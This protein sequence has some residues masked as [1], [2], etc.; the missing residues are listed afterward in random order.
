MV[1]SVGVPI[2]RSLNVLKINDLLAY[3]SLTNFM[4]SVVILLVFFFNSFQQSLVCEIFLPTFLLESLIYY[5]YN[6][7]QHNNIGDMY[8]S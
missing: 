3:D 8:A 5:F 7:E 1:I 2:F 4:T 6:I